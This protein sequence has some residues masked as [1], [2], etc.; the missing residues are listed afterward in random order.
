[1]FLLPLSL[2]APPLILIPLILLPILFTIYPIFS[3]H[4]NCQL[5]PPDN[6][7]SSPPFVFLSVRVMLTGGTAPYP[8]WSG[9]HISYSWY[10]EACWWV[11]KL[12][13]N[14]TYQYNDPFHP[15][16]YQMCWSQTDIFFTRATA[17]FVLWY[18]KWAMGLYCHAQ[19]LSPSS[20][21]LQPQDIEIWVLLGGTRGGSSNAL[22]SNMSSVHQRGSVTCTWPAI[23]CVDL[24]IQFRIWDELR[25][26]QPLHAWDGPCSTTG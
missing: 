17:G 4:L 13:P 25:T 10:H 26:F 7:H 19:K 22:I 24:R 20:D 5:A 12:Y 11:V 18:F 14:Q 21:I 8:H 6:H 1:M 2:P 9:T 16:N 3:L 15:A 23:F